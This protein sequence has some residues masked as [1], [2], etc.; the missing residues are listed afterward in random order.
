MG[1]MGT[2]TLF[3]R[4]GDENN[5]GGMLPI[6]PNMQGVPPHWLAYFGVSS[7]DSSA[8]KATTLGGKLI[9]P[10]S[11]IPDVGRFAVVQDPQGAVFAIFETKH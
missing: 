9:V 4:P 5:A 6:P 7:C 1:P 2:Y 8:K 10:P 3:K 11:D